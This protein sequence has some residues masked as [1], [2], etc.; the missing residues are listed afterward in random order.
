MFLGRG[1]VDPV[2]C[3]ACSRAPVA[4]FKPENRECPFAAVSGSRARAVGYTDSRTR[5]LPGPTRTKV[6]PQGSEAWLEI[7][8]WITCHASDRRALPLRG[9]RSPQ[10]QSVHAALQTRAQPTV[11][12]LVSA[13]DACVSQAASSAASPTASATI[14]RRAERRT[15]RRAECRAEGRAEGCAER[16]TER[17]AERHAECR[18]ACVR[19]C[20]CA[21]VLV[22]VRC[23]RSCAC[24]HAHAH[25]TCAYCTCASC[26]CAC[27]CRTARPCAR[28]PTDGR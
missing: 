22:C 25:A 20:V 10:R 15:E 4:R 26:A 6:E 16:H 3:H 2:R 24:P 13:F 17:R 11:H 18:L 19:E 21:C 23:A 14:E 28:M 5:A 27:A 1:S 7:P 9:R 8:R 12:I